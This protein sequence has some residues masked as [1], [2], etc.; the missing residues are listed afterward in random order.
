MSVL[1]QHQQL[2][3]QAVMQERLRDLIERQD[4]VDDD[5]DRCVVVR[6]GVVRACRQLRPVPLQ[7]QR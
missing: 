4:T 2:M 6:P 5:Y 1:S 3:K 7:L